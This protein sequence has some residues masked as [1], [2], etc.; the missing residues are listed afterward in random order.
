[1]S[2]WT[3]D[4]LQR[5]ADAVELRVASQ[6]PDGTLRPYVTI[7]HV[8]V[9][10]ALYIR[11]A[12][13]PSNGWFRRAREAGVGR[14]SAGGVERSVTFEPASADVRDAVDAAYHLK[15]DRYGPAPVGAVTSPDVLETTLRVRPR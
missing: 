2:T 5:V 13:G 9:G 8:G 10:D 14:I 1:M 6:R 12:G 15:Y 11:S 3:R 7:W 4:E